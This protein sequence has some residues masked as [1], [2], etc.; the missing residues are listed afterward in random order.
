MY[1]LLLLTHVAGWMMIAFTQMFDKVVMQ[2]KSFG[3][4]LLGTSIERSNWKAPK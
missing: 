4:V 2:I 1:L 3:Y